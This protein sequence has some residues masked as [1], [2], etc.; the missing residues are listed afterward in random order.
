MVSTIILTILCGIGLG[1]SSFFGSYLLSNR[2]VKSLANTILG[3]LILALT[4]RVG[5]AVFYNFLEL[6]LIIRNLGLAANLA[7]APLLYFYGLALLKRPFAW[8]RVYFIHFI[9][10]AI[11]I[12]FC[13]KIPNATTDI[14]WMVSYSFILKFRYCSKT[15]DKVASMF[16][17]CC[18][19][20]RRDSFFNRSK[21]YF[22]LPPL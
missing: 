13:W 6:P 1:I 15:E 11:Y 14:V 22:L 19:S 9:P 16:C 3:I 5:K 18:I 12:L 20:P 10:S 7:A 21:V 8:R 2:K 4:F 17:L